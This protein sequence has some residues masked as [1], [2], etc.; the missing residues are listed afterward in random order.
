MTNLLHL[1]TKDGRKSET[2]GHNQHFYCWK[3]ENSS[4]YD[5]QHSSI[6]VEGIDTFVHITVL[7]VFEGVGVSTQKPPSGTI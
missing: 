6:Y 3:F 4:K 1:R 7:A 5:L 2:G